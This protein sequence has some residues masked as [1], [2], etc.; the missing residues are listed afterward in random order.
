[1]CIIFIM[2]K[3]TD[4]YN[5]LLVSLNKNPF[6]APFIAAGYLLL[7]ALLLVSVVPMLL[8]A[9]YITFRPLHWRNPFRKNEP[10]RYHRYNPDSEICSVHQKE[11][12]EKSLSIAYGLSVSSMSDVGRLYPY[13]GLWAGLGGCVVGEEKSE[14]KKVCTECDELAREYLDSTN[15]SPLKMQIGA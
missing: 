8:V 13:H 1:M 10:I 9:I 11:L 15:E 6:T 12:I 7:L 3:T 14:M 2:I 5:E 4:K